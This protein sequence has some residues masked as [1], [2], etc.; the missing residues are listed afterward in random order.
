[1]VLIP[2]VGTKVESTR[3]SGHHVTSEDLLAHVL[4]SV[5]DVEDDYRV[6]HRL[7]SQPLA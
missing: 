2:H 5:E 7:T 1:M 4:E 3:V 6:V